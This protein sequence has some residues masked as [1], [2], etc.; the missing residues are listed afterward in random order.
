ME[1]V[2]HTVLKVWAQR[3]LPQQRKPK[4]LKK[5]SSRT[6]VV[7]KAKK[8]RTRLPHRKKNQVSLQVRQVTNPRRWKE[9]PLPLPKENPP[10]PTD[11]QPG[12]S[13]APT[14]DPTQDPT[15]IPPQTTATTSEED[16]PRDLTEYVE[17]YCKAGKQWL[18]TVLEQKEQ[19]YRT[20]FHELLRIGDPHIENFN[21]A[22]KA[23]VLKCIKDSSGR[24]KW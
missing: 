6:L 3:R 5:G 15:Q 24:L 23:A 14:T 11:P 18:D 4:R 2:A 20:L 9:R 22:D 19:A 8:V 10:A 1:A 17:S 13:K 12:S 7:R 16:A 21:N